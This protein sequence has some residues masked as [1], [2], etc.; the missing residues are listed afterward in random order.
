MRSKGPRWALLPAPS[1]ESFATQGPSS[2][3][4]EET[5]SREGFKGAGFGGLPAVRCPTYSLSVQLRG[6]TSVN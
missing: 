6:A 2:S 3:R 5:S 4:R 1:L